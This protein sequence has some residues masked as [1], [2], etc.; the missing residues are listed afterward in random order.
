MAETTCTPTAITAASRHGHDLRA[1]GDDTW[2]VPG[3]RASVASA[4]ESAEDEEGLTTMISM[5]LSAHGRDVVRCKIRTS[6]VVPVWR[7]TAHV[8]LHGVDLAHQLYCQKPI[9]RGIAA[10]LSIYRLFDN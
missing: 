8:V 3:C 1:N 5:R 4:V 9:T 10:V 7:K 6:R 2:R